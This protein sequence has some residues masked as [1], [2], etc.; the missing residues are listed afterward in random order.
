M[1]FVIVVIVIVLE[2]K[3]AK[4]EVI[5][6]SYTRFPEW[7]PLLFMLI[8]H[9]KHMYLHLYYTATTIPEGSITILCLYPWSHLDDTTLNSYLDI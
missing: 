4:I 6:V 9:Y 3:V 1:V 2:K 5:D 7:L 8:F